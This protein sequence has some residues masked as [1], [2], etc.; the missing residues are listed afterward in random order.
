ML[1]GGRVEAGETLSEALGREL[2]EE[3]GLRPVAP[4]TI[5]FAVDIRRADGAYSAITFDVEAGG[6]LLPDDPDGFVLAAAWVPIVTAFERLR[7]VAWYDCEPLARYLAGEAPP[8]TT[9]VAGPA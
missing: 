6:Q 1:P 3:T 2:A 4:G 5:A 7:C 8:G 9:Y